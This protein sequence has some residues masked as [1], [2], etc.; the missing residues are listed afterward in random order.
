[1]S[2]TPT[3]DNMR[4]GS[5]GYVT[6]VQIL[7]L[8]TRTLQY[9]ADL[10]VEASVAAS[11]HVHENEEARLL[12]VLNYVLDA[13]AWKCALAD[14]RAAAVDAASASWRDGYDTGFA[15]G[16]SGVFESDGSYK[17]A[18]RAHDAASPA[19]PKPPDQ[20]GVA[21]SPTHLGGAR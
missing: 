6:S 12:W 2:T 1:M 5:G 14:E 16:A 19:T 9:R 10:M 11:K 7:P 4:R 18:A 3:E 21:G 15:E 8:A 20:Q 13:A 17:D